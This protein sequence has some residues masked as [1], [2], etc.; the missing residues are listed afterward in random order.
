MCTG[1][2]VQLF[3]GC[4]DNQTSSDGAFVFIYC[5]YLLSPPATPLHLHLPPLPLPPLSTHAHRGVTEDGR[6]VWTVCVHIGMWV[7]VYIYVHI[8]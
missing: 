4:Q 6:Q 1:G 5:I 3:S 2:D 7:S 8:M